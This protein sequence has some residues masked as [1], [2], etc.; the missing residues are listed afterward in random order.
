MRTSNAFRNYRG[1]INYENVLLKEKFRYGVIVVAENKRGK[2]TVGQII[3][4]ATF[5]TGK[6]T[7]SKKIDESLKGVDS[8]NDEELS[9]LENY[10]KYYDLT[11]SE[12]SQEYYPLIYKEDL[13]SGS[14]K[15]FYEDFTKVPLE[16]KSVNRSIIPIKYHVYPKYFIC[17]DTECTVEYVY[18]PKEGKSLTQTCEYEKSPIPARVIA[19]GIV[20]EAL[21]N[22]GLYEEA[23][24][25]RDRY[26]KSLQNCLLRKKVKR[27]KARGWY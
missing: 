23:L 6:K 18:L 11:I 5:L 14:G 21:M 25:W 13:K 17:D 8:F 1:V 20:S 27:V 4:I 24:S 15:F 22:E 3:S 10:Y 16:I 12:L 19:E 26:V 9:E 2:M 7:L